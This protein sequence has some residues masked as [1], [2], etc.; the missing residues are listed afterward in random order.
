MVGRVRAV[1]SAGDDRGTCRLH[2]VARAGHLWQDRPRPA[3]GFRSRALRHG[4][5]CPNCRRATVYRRLLTGTGRAIV[6]TEYGSMDVHRPIPPWARATRKNGFSWTHRNGF[7][8]TG[9]HLRGDDQRTLIVNGFWDRIATDDV[10]RLSRQA[11]ASWR[12]ATLASRGRR[13]AWTS[14]PR[15]S[16]PQCWPRPSRSP[17]RRD[18]AAG[19]LHPEFRLGITHL[20][21]PSGEPTVQLTHRARSACRTPSK[22][23]FLDR[24]RQRTGQGNRKRRHA[25]HIGNRDRH[26]GSDRPAA[27]VFGRGVASEREPRGGRYR[28]P[29]GRGAR[30]EGQRGGGDPVVNGGCVRRHRGLLGTRARG[31]ARKLPTPS[32]ARR[33]S[34]SLRASFRPISRGRGHLADDRYAAPHGRIRRGRSGTSHAV[35][36]ADLNQDGPDMRP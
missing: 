35:V 2:G 21:N 26:R 34:R 29:P 30:C 20:G 19:G 1:Y 18:G 13:C 14:R 31:T 23:R 27:G 12:N 22:Q 8:R 10:G 25:G 3:G 32:L 9:Q 11:D 28:S 17:G 7:A 5:V 15:G 33:Q 6:F 24:D 4:L 16:V 36:Y